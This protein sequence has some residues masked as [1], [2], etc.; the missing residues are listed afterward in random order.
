[1]KFKRFEPKDLIY[2]TIVAKPDFNFIIHSGTVY[3]QKQRMHTGNFSNNI[4]HIKSGEASLHELNINRPSG[5][6]IYSFIKKDSTR[7][8]YK[9]VSTSNFDDEVQFAYGDTLTQQYPVTSSLSRIYVPAGPEFSSSVAPAHNNKKYVRALANVIRTQGSFSNG[10][11]YGTLGTSEINMVCVPGIFCGSG[12]EKGSIKLRY[13][14]TGTLLAEAQDINKDGRLIQVSGTTTG[15]TIGNV[16]YNQGLILLT[17]STALDPSYTDYYKSTSALS[18]PSWTNFGTGITQGGT[19]LSHGS[20]TGSAYTVDFKGINK[21]P[22]L[23]MYAFSREG[24]MNLSSNPTFLEKTEEKSYDFTSSSYTERIRNTKKT[25][26]SP[27]SDHEEDFENVTYISKVGIYDKDKNLI[28]I[29]TLATP[30]KKTE[31]REY[32]IKMGIDF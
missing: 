13:S 3:L 30:I 20:V 1:M 21:I 7:Y 16:V 12:I 22:T 14:V 17:S 4:K 25:N 24:E 27:Y 32:M 10:L 29:A 18:S 8:S 2:N 23:T 19:T 15:H 6:L 9:S 28:A 11:T 31:K 5:S 26:K